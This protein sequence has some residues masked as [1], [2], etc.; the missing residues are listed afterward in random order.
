[1]CAKVQYFN[2]L[3]MPTAQR[4]NDDKFRKSCMTLQTSDYKL[5]DMLT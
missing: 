1:M 3:D 4:D 5:W 2:T